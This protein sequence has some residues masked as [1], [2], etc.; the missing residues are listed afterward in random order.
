MDGIICDYNYVFDPNVKLK[1][2]FD[3]LCIRDRVSANL[4]III[5]SVMGIAVAVFYQGM[6]VAAAF[7]TFYSGLPN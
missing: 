1:R 3:Q 6:D 4:C 5:G 7:N 2:Y